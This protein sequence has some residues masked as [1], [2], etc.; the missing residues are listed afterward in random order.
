MPVVVV[1]VV[2]RQF[3]RH[4]NMARITTRVLKDSHVQ[5][6]CKFTAS[7]AGTLTH[8]DNFPE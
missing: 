3:I 5:F 2:V 7:K 8:Q 1:V 4:H 6:S